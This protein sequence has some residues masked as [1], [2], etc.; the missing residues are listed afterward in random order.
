MKKI[1]AMVF[2]LAAYV[3]QPAAAFTTATPLTI[4]GLNWSVTNVSNAALFSNC[5][6]M[7]RIQVDLTGAYGSP[8]YTASGIL[9]C[10][11][12]Q[13]PVYLPAI[14]TVS[15]GS[16]GYG[17]ALYIQDVRLFCVLNSQS[18]SNSVCSIYS[19]ATGSVLSTLSL[20]YS[21]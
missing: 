17:L 18:L 12:A 20:T 6:Q 14:G 3:A 4:V 15:G 9:F 11:S 10:N 19:I 1:L 7:T 5:P 8:T 13:G 2:V 21:P 16:T